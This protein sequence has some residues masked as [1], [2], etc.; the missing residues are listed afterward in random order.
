MSAPVS[1]R[2]TPVDHGVQIRFINDLQDTGGGGTGSG[3]P[4]KDGPKKSSSRYGV[5]VRVQG[6]GGQPYVVLKEGEKGDS[7]GVQLRTQPPAYNSLPRRR[8]DGVIQGPYFSS[9]DSANLRRAHSHG[10]LLERE[11]SSDDFTDQLRRPLG[12]GRSGSYGNLDGGIGVGSERER[13]KERMERNQWGGSYQTGLNGTLGRGRGGGSHYT[14]AESV[15]ISQYSEQYQSQSVPSSNRQT[16]VTRF[17]NKFEGGPATQAD[18]PGVTATGRYPGMNGEDRH[19]SFIP[20]KYTSPPS[21]SPGSAYSSVGRSP[22]SVAK[23]T[24][25]T[26][27]ANQW[28][29]SVDSVDV[30]PDLLLDQGQSSGSEFSTEDQIQQII[31]DVLRQGSTE[32]DAAIKR[33]VRVICSK[34]QGLKGAQV[35]RP[36]DSLKEELEK[37]LDDNVQL[38]EQ[39][40]RKS[41]ELH[42]MHSELTQLRMDR[43]YAESHV[44]ELEDQLAG[45]QQELRRESDKGA[46]SDTMH[47]ELMATRADLAEAAALCQRHEDLLRQKERELT[48]L[49]GALKDE[50]S[51]HDKEIE[52]LRE[53]YRQDMERLR[54]SME[55]VSQSQAS[56]EAERHRVNSSVRTLQQQLEECRDEGNHWREQFQSGREELRKTKQELLQARLEKEEFEEELK[57]V[58]EKV[59]AMKQQIPD[60]KHTQTLSQEVERCRADLQ[61]A[62]AEMDKLKENLDKKTMEIVLLKKSKQE[63]EAEQKYEIDRLKDQSRRSKEEL[64]K[65]HERAKQLAEPSLLEAL[66]KELSE[67][68]EEVERLRSRL[69]S[70]EEELQSESNKLGSLQSQSISLS[71]EHRDLEE[72]NSRMKER[73]TRLESQLQER[74]SQS[75]EVEQEQQE[76]TRKLK[77]HLEEARRENVKLGL[78]RDELARNLEERERDREGMRKENTQLDDLRR[79]QERALDKLN[80]EMERLSASSREEVRL[81]Q[82]QL[83]E[84]KE[85]WKKEQHD[86]QKNTKEKLS[87]LEKAQSTIHSL[88]EELARQKKELFAC[89][90]EK[91]NIVLDKELLTNRVK[92]LESELETQRSTHTDRSREIRS[93]E[94]KVK[95]LELE[96]DEERS[97][98]EMLTERIT[99][100]RDQIEQLRAELMQERTSKQDLE[101]DKNALERQIKEYKSRLAEMEGQSRSSTGVSQLES[102]IQELEERLRTE[103]REKTTVL[104]SQRRLER[105]LKD[106]N[107]TLDDERQQHIE[108]RDQLTLRVKALKRQVDEGEAEAERLEG[109]RRKAIRDMEEQLEQRE[110]LQS[111][112]TALENELKR[113]IQQARQSALNSSVLSSE[114]EDDDGLYDHSSITSILTESNL[115]TSSC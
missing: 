72:A 68:Q 44:R 28:S 17:I 89:Y 67:A 115:K 24:A 69:L 50:V 42:Q 96:L 70:A 45:L 26:S 6:I 111:R 37:R 97:N 94:D 49:K 85:K 112:V 98:G 65:A 86:S 104:S 82:A 103:E 53:Q 106:L 7:Y 83:D 11:S 55:Q 76:E 54:T 74:L 34:I 77:Q 51:T 92:H 47:M 12:D 40:G 39:L 20:N 58:Q 99:R 15:E 79:Q 101:L 62:Q 48:A 46:Q 59:T 107:I 57:E 8:E 38:Q 75:M 31:Y 80:K 95:H 88:H 110:A 52:T 29:T 10:S 73:I 109:L 23:V 90:E 35:S 56:I 27:S 87:E 5:A 93:M 63:L 2:K 113:K 102:K 3:P 18:N 25:V 81:L 33:R 41:T 14:S 105:K 30:T 32:G 64:T 78:E 19:S 36:D 66:R 21:S 22:G 9:G 100:S 91:D 60:P 114:D 1:G 108:Q 16:P 71:Q 61:K 13:P 84:Q 43:E 4:R